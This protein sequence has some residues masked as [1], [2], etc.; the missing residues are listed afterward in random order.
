MIVK[1]DI[2]DI[3]DV[4]AD[5]KHLLTLKSPLDANTV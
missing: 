4:R 5:S 1:I 3:D 2:V